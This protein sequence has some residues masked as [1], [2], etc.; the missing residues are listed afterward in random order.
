MTCDEPLSFYLE[1]KRDGKIVKEYLNQHIHTALSYITEVKNSR[2][3]GLARLYAHDADFEE[4]LRLS[5]VLHDVGKVFYQ[6]VKLNMRE[7][8]DTGE[9]YLSFAGHEYI[10]ATIAYDFVSILNEERNAPYYDA[11][12]FSVLYHHHAMS[13]REK[14]LDELRK[15]L[16]KMH[17]SE[18]QH[19]LNKLRSLL[20]RFLPDYNDVF[21]RVLER[22]SGAPNR[23]LDVDIIRRRIYDRVV[24]ANKPGYRKLAFLLLDSL[25]VCDYLAASEHR[26][27]SSRFQKIVK[28]FYDQW[29]SPTVFNQGCCHTT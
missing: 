24:L 16:Q 22:L 23:L 28:E 12:T 26:G 5:I 9:R 6:N 7:N 25:I 14:S 17:P 10:S 15:R 11:V 27:G 4:L 1:S 3:N 29:L 2:S 13:H 18:Y 21:E 8:K 20:D 19:S